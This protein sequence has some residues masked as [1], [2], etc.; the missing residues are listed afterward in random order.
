[1]NTSSYYPRS[2]LGE[3]SFDWT[4]VITGAIK[5]GSDIYGA[6]T[7]KEITEIQADTLKTLGKT[8][9]EQPKSFF[10]GNAGTVT[11]LAIAGIGGIA[12]IVLLMSMKK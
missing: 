1:M 6:Y 7:E 4:G 12:L 5:A 9:A 8:Q 3:D 10:T 2:M 11:Y